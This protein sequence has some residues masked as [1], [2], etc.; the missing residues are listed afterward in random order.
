MASD[1]EKGFDDGYRLAQMKY[2]ERIDMQREN[3]SE[4]RQIDV[5]MIQQRILAV[6]TI[7]IGIYFGVLGEIVPSIMLIG[8]G[9]LL[10]KTETDCINYK[11]E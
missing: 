4:N 10:I 3:R 5:D 1:Y 9:V 8:I 7:I 6:F 11:E 2:E